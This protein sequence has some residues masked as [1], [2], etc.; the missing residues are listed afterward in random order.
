[1]R[2]AATIIMAFCLPAAGITADKLPLKRGIFVDTNV[3]CSERSNATV[4]SF[5]GDQLNTSRT[6]GHISKVV[7]KGKSY[8]VDLDIEH[9]DGGREQTTWSLVIKNSKTMKITNNFGSWDQRWC[10]DQM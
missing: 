4:V 9:M 7:K 10:S 3:K 2:I 5:W 8:T 6:V 1:M